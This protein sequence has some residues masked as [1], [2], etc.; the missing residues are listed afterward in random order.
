MGMVIFWRKRMQ[1]DE[2]VQ[3]KESAMPSSTLFEKFSWEYQV[4]QNLKFDR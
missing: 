4:S 1:I 3:L 2:K